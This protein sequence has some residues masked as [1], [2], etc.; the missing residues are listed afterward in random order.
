MQFQGLVQAAT[1]GTYQGIYSQFSNLKV[2]NV[3]VDRVRSRAY[4]L[5]SVFARFMHTKGFKYDLKRQV[6]DNHRNK[7][8]ADTAFPLEWGNPEALIDGVDTCVLTVCMQLYAHAAFLF[9]PNCMTDSC[10]S[11]RLT[12]IPEAWNSVG[13]TDTHYSWNYSTF[14]RAV[15]AL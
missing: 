12:K 4:E 10:T 5:N 13:L 3:L 14:N 11:F 1:R 7:D 15:G 6:K 2:N 8:N 9:V